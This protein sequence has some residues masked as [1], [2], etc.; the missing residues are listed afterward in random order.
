MWDK[1]EAQKDRTRRDRGSNWPRGESRRLSQIEH[2]PGLRDVQKL[3]SA[4]RASRD[5]LAPAMAQAD[6]EGSTILLP[7]V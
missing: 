3:A 1:S 2:A 5:R 6:P 7:L 4:D